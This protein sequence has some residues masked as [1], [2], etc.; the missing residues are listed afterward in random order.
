MQKS[1]KC[2]LLV[3][4]IRC[5]L[6]RIKRQLLAPTPPHLPADVAAR[7]QS[8]QEV[9]GNLSVESCVALMQL[10]RFTSVPRGVC[11]SVCVRVCGEG[12]VTCSSGSQ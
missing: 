8:S 6:S 5:D 4:E 10:R 11:L 3:P 7:G 1:A 2:L 12:G 9:N